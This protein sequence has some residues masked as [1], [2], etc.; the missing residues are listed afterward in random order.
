MESDQPQ[1]AP[2]STTRVEA[3]SDGV[4]AI[5]IT[6]LIFGIRVPEFSGAPAPGELGHQLWARWPSYLSFAISFTMIG[7]FWIA[8]HH[9]FQLIERATRPLL[10]LNTAFLMCVSFIP[11]PTSVLGLYSHQRMSMV[12]Y[13]ATLIVT[14]FALYVVWFY[15]STGRRLL[16]DEV[17]QRVIQMVGHR[18]LAGCVVYA[19]T[20]ALS[21]IN[22]T[23][24]HI[25]IALIP[26]A[27]FVPSRVDKYIEAEP[28]DNKRALKG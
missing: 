26:L 1:H 14:A 12:F 6:L 10:W 3:F 20:L 16:S 21:F 18:I 23:A 2:L 9:M 25:L 11:Y 19:V 8:H 17:P 4:F 7:I 13:C 22:L 15:A 27:Y 28:T 5:A 24:G